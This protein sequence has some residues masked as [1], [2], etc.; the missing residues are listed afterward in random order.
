MRESAS[1]LAVT[2]W[3]QPITRS[4]LAGA[5]AGRV[6]VGLACRPGARATSPGRPS[7]PGRSCRAPIAP[8][9]STCAAMRQDLADGDHAGAADAGDQDAVRVRRS[10]AAPA[11]AGAAGG[12][13]V[14]WLTPAFF[15]FFS[16]P[17]STVTKLGQK[18]LTHEKSLLQD[19]WLIWRLRP[20]SVSSGSTDRQFDC[21]EQSPQPSQTASLMTTRLAGSG[22][23]P[24]FRRRRFSD[25]A[26]LVVDHGRHARQLAQFALH[27]ASVR[28][29][30]AR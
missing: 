4:A 27:V 20:N 19:D 26:G 2:I 24:F 3:S 28:C 18:P 16:V 21:T 14:A 7:A 22:Y 6:Q 1:R 23:S 30:G 5:D 12:A 13:S 10:S 29:G 17:P 11:R 25:G 9:P 15:G 8:L